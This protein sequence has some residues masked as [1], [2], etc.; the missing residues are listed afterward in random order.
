MHGH[1]HFAFAGWITQAL[2]TLMVAYL[3]SKGQA[4]AFKK[5]KTLLI[6][7]LFT[8]YGMLCSF[9]IQGYGFFSILFSTLSVFVSYGSPLNFGKI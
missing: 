5:Y 4:E 6:F 9:P 2:M 8:A 7:N 3:V 1:S